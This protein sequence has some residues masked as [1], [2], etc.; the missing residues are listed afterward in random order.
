MTV[1]TYP[2][3]L[4]APDIEPYRKG[5]TG[6]EFVTTFDSGIAGPHVMINAVTHGNEICGAIALD[7]LFKAGVKPLRGKLT[8]GFINHMAYHTFDSGKPGDSRFVDEDFNRVWVEDR[9]DG[10][11]D[12]VELRRARELRPLFDTVD[13]MLD[14]HS[15]STYSKPL[16]ICNG[17][18]KEVALTEKV[19]YPG[20]IMCGSGH[21]VGKRLIEYTPFN[22]TSNNKVAMLVECGQ[23]WAAETGR[24]AMDTALHFLRATET[25]STEFLNKHF[26]DVGRN[27]EKA[28]MWEVTAGVTAKT[29]NFNFVQEFI[30]M[31]V[32][33]KAGTVI[34]NDGGE[35]VV[36]PYDNCLLMMPNYTAGAGARRLRLCKRMR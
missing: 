18:D 1:R 34:A 23:H 26:S 5:N 8:L 12:T 31:E 30:G 36:T 7:K 27:P 21:V 33:E 11:E 4:T 20:H 16:M 14:I 13:M 24:I 25:V 22:D 3:E 17:L 10:P 6:I 19:N 28:E 9:L 35:E 32:I 29:D 15:M 2:V